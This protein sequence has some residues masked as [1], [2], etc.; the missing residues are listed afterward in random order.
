MYLWNEIEDEFLLLQ[1]SNIQWMPKSYTG[2]KRVSS[3]NGPGKTK[4]PRVDKCN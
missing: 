2:E 4:F 3:T 1:P